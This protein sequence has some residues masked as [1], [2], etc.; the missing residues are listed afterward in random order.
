M[1]FLT[2][3][4][5][6]NVSS[7]R[8]IYRQNIILLPSRHTRVTSG[9]RH[10][11]DGFAELLW[12]ESVRAIQCIF[13]SP[14]AF[15]NCNWNRFAGTT[16][17]NDGGNRRIV[18]WNCIQRCRHYFRLHNGRCTR[19]PT[20]VARGYH[21]RCRHGCGVFMCYIQGVHGSSLEFRCFHLLGRLLPRNHA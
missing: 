8:S 6:Y 21:A 9:L 12:S 5:K 18:C 10:S 11:S 17:A 16:S 2:L 1:C 3:A 7:G 14:G 4:G 15:R 13:Y 19:W 20:S